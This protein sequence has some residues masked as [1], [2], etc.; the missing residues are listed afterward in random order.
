MDL[1]IV[2]VDKDVLVGHADSLEKALFLS[3]KKKNELIVVFL[4][5]TSEKLSFNVNTGN[6]VMMY[7]S[8]EY[9]MNGDLDK[10]DEAFAKIIEGLRED[11]A[12]L[13]KEH[14]KSPS[15]IMCFDDK[16]E[17]HKKL[18]NDLSTFLSPRLIPGKM[19]KVMGF[20]SKNKVK[21]RPY[22]MEA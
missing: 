18:V 15:I 1:Y 8:Y 2:F 11:A 4:D 7:T 22:D 13:E 16:R 10:K 17:G 12:S 6:L 21:Y 14:G 19:D 5:K 9:P 20:V 3:Q